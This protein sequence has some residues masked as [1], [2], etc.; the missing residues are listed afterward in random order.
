[1]TDGTALPLEAIEAL[2]L[3]DRDRAFDDALEAHGLLSSGLLTEEGRAWRDT[4]CAGRRLEV[5]IST[6]EIDSSLDGWVGATDTVVLAANSEGAISARWPTTLLATRLAQALA[7][8]SAPQPTLEVPRDERRHASFELRLNDGATHR[9]LRAARAPNGDWTASTSAG[10][11]SS[12][13]PISSRA[14]WFTLIRL[15]E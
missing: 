5:R 1:M 8:G 14:L 9:R 7:L 3:G 2:A 13:G 4:V 12:L 15:L 6:P 11:A 10:S